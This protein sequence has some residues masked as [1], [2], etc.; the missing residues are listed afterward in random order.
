M[1]TI[2]DVL[3][4]SKFVSSDS[5]AE[6]RKWG[7]VE[8]VDDKE[9]PVVDAAPEVSDVL[10]QIDEVIQG[11]GYVLAR[12]TDLDALRVFASGRKTGTLVFVEPDGHTVR[13][14]TE[15]AVTPAGY[16]LPW[17]TEGI[18]AAMTNG[19]SYLDLGKGKAHVYFSDSVDL[20]FDDE[21]MFLRLVPS[22]RP[23]S[24]K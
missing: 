10:R 21:L 3:T 20:Y 6:F 2:V 15:Y 4:A 1:P 8:E 22:P 19:R 12:E 9:T 24:S 5:L 14:S 18:A 16:L 17:P 11:E 7:L 23:G 13:T